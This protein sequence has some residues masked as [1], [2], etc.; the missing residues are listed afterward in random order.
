MEN[1]I[2]QIEIKLL[3]LYKPIADL[4]GDSVDKIAEQLRDINVEHKKTNTEIWK[5]YQDKVYKHLRYISDIQRNYEE[6]KKV[7]IK[8][9][10]DN[11]TELVINKDDK[12][13]LNRNANVLFVVDNKNNRKLL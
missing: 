11:E 10:Q 2:L 4:A 5:I 8:E 1:K 12:I 6:Y 3:N 9:L 13:E 7:L